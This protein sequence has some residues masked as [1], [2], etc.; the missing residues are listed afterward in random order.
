MHYSIEKNS[1]RFLWRALGAISFLFN[2]N[3]SHDQCSHSSGNLNRDPGKKF[4]IFTHFLQRRR[5]Q[6]DSRKRLIIGIMSEDEPWPLASKEKVN[7][8]VRG[9]RHFLF[10]PLPGDRKVTLTDLTEL[11]SEYVEKEIF[12]LNI[13]LS[14]ASSIQRIK[15]IKILSYLKWEVDF[16]RSTLDLKKTKQD[17]AQAHLRVFQPTGWLPSFA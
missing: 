9:S 1:S 17:E 15:Y 16:Q 5:G 14:V 11:T 10:P 12:R 3:K 13:C 4:C 2:S 6:V 8:R 7:I